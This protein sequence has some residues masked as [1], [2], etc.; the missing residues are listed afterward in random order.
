MRWLKKNTRNNDTLVILKESSLGT[1]NLIRVNVF[2]NSIM[3]FVCFK[4]YCKVVFFFH[5]ISSTCKWNKKIKR[6]YL[7]F[8]I[9]LAYSK[10]GRGRLVLGHS[11]PR[12]CVC[13]CWVTKL[14]ATFS[15]YY[16]SKANNILINNF[17]T[18]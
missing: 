8:M 10:E 7:I 3:R 17:W 4:L 12:L 16:Q 9:C 1:G 6:S 5:R 18:I 15:S 11:V 14:N 2:S 13:V